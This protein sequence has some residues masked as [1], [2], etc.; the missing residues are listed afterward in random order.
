GFSALIGPDLKHVF[1]EQT[2]LGRKLCMI[3]SQGQGALLLLYQACQPDLHHSLRERHPDSPFHAQGSAL[4]EAPSP[5]HT[6][7]R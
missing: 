2:T 5:L 7:V 6:G 3:G 1:V 4:A